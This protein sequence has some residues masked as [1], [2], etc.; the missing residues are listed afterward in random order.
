MKCPVCGAKMIDGK[1]CRYCGVTN[2]QV[3]NASNLEAKKAFKEGRKSDV[4]YTTDI[5]K[6]VNK[7]K[8][9]LLTAFLGLFGVGNFYVGRYVKGTFCAASY[10][11]SLIFT[12]LK[13]FAESYNWS[14]LPVLQVFMSIGVYCMIANMLFWIH[15]MLGF[16]FKNYKVPVVLAKED[17]NMKHHSLKNIKGK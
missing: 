4:C 9:I 8:L 3:Y 12:M 13:M 7:R 5:P 15:D 17:V 6:D 2:E 14:A 10:G 11:L 1:I 16:I